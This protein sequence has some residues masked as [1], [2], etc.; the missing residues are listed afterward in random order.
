MQLPEICIRR[1]V[2]ATVVSLLLV[3]L[4]FGEETKH[5]IEPL[6]GAQTRAL[7]G[8]SRPR[9]SPITARSAEVNVRAARV[10][11]MG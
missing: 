3:I 10:R 7:P 5:T 1:P 8:F 11:A 9:R 2:F 4:G 6:I